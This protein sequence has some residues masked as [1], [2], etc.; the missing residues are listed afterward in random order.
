MVELCGS[1]SPVEKCNPMM[2][3]C[4]VS[5]S[6]CERLGAETNTFVVSEGRAAMKVL[7]SQYL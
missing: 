4:V 5:D 7:D 6:S 1:Q 3:A 2:A